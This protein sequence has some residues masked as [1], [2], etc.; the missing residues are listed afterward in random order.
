MHFATVKHGGI[1]NKLPKSMN[2]TL[3]QIYNENICPRKQN[4]FIL[5]IVNEVISDFFLPEPL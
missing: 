3:S 2:L 4:Y 1:Y 5:Q